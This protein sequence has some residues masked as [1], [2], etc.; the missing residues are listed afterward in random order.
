M[1]QFTASPTRK[2]TG[3]LLGALTAGVLAT[4]GLGSA[5]T[6]NATCASFFGINSGGDCTS[7]LTSIAIAIGTGAAAHADGL[8]GT[9]FAVGTGAKAGTSDALTF[10]TAM[11]DNSNALAA[12]IFGIAT[13]LGSNGYVFTQPSGG[14]FGRLGFNMALNVSFGTTSPAGST[15]QATGV[16]NVAIN[17]L[18]DGTTPGMVHGVGASGVLTVAASLG[19]ANNVVITGGNLN[20]SFNAFGSGNTVSAGPGPVAVAGS[21][22][23]TGQTVKKMGPGFNINNGIGIGGAAATPPTAATGRD[24]ITA[25]AAAGTHSRAGVAVSAA[26]KR[27]TT[28]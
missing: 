26:A 27:S 11:G 2:F 21:I 15:A 18:S 4:A 23:Q 8:F 19:G 5:P 10:A 13:Q 17:L 16:G 28:K 20:L 9:A 25:T 3:A 22:L 12:G 24:T 6:A 7:N 1:G 14:L